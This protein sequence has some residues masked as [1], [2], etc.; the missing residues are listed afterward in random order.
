MHPATSYSAMERLKPVSKT[1]GVILVAVLALIGLLSVTRGTPLRRVLYGSDAHPPTAS[2]SAFPRF[3]A[4]LSSVHLRP[5][6]KVEPL[7]NGNGTYPRLWDDLRSARTS[8]TTTPATHTIA[9]R[10][11]HPS[12]SVFFALGLAIS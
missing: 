5:G 6:N 11:I 4:L 8:I 2:D 10:R 3:V 12:A 7:L 1:V 9:A